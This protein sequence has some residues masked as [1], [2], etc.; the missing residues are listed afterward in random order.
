MIATFILNDYPHN[1][2]NL[3]HLGQTQWPSVKMML[4]WTSA[5]VQPLKMGAT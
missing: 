1:P 2:L 3:S 4:L 5:Q